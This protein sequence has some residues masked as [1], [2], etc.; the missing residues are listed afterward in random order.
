MYCNTTL[1]NIRFATH[2]VVASRASIH[3]QPSSTGDI[4]AITRQPSR[5]MQ[6]KQMID[7]PV[8]GCRRGTRAPYSDNLRVPMLTLALAAAVHIAGLT[9]TTAYSEVIDAPYRVT[10]RGWL[11]TELL[12][13]A[14]GLPFGY[15]KVLVIF[16]SRVIAIGR[17]R[18][19]ENGATHE[20]R[21]ELKTG[22]GLLRDSK[23]WRDRRLKC[24]PSLGKRN[25][26]G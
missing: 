5:S 3:D 23:H 20:K 26:S 22:Q 1:G 8:D 25:W 4:V 19:R 6:L 18:K 17:K 9:V 16:V 15:F 2:S 12:A 14:E 7:L 24:P 10:N 13:V 11:G 21:L